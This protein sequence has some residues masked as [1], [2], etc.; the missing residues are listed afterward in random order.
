MKYILLSILFL[1]LS[2]TG[3]ADQ[4]SHNPSPFRFSEAE[5]LTA[6]YYTNP[7]LE[8]SCDLDTFLD[9]KCHNPEIAARV[10]ECIQVIPGSTPMEIQ[11]SSLSIGRRVVISC[12][13]A[14]LHLTEQL[15]LQ[16]QHESTNLA[17]NLVNGMRTHWD[18][19]LLGKDVTDPTLA[20]LPTG[21]YFRQ[22]LFQAGFT[23]L[24]DVAALCVVSSQFGPIAY[25]MK[26]NPTIS[27]SAI[28]IAKKEMQ[29]LGKDRARALAQ[30]R[31]LWVLKQPKMQ[32]LATSRTSDG[33]LAQRE[34]DY[35]FNI[36]GQ[37]IADCFA[38]PE[39]KRQRR[40]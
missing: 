9:T 30:Q 28:A 38:T 16:G 33:Y 29:W 5:L 2:C 6:I 36:D 20:Y 15:I 19:T 3:A 34:F 10:A 18:I 27:T 39:A 40:A 31:Q 14:G 17:H 32:F 24:K 37:A 1:H 13:V 12:F 4:S 21:K 25:F 7:D 35:A 23:S 8:Q 22:A 26:Q 11:S